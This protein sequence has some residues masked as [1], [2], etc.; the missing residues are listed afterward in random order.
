MA[1]VG[2]EPLDRADVDDAPAASTTHVRQRGL[3]EEQRC[4]QVDGDGELPLFGQDLGHRSLGHDPGVV[5]EDVDPAAPLDDVL[6]RP[7]DRREDAEIGLDVSDPR[8]AV[9]RVV[10]RLALDDRDG[11]PFLEEAVDDAAAYPT[12]AAGHQR[13]LAFSCTVPLATDRLGPVTS[14]VSP[15]M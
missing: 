2:A 12:S 9:Q 15:A 7:A 1:G 11:R 4:A 8:M 3:R 13:N 6:H 10:Q 5:D 14:T